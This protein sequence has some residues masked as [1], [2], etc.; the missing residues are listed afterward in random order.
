M[1]YRAVGMELR[2]PFFEIVQ[3]KRP[4]VVEVTI[5]S[6]RTHPLAKYVRRIESENLLL[7]L[8]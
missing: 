1:P 6:D 5:D 8:F 2:I 3:S 4:A 7:F